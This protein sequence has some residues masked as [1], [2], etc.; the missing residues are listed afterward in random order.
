MLNLLL[1]PHDSFIYH[2]SPPLDSTLVNRTSIYQVGDSCLERVKRVE[3]SGFFSF[4][5]VAAIPLLVN[6]EAPEL[7]ARACFKCQHS[8]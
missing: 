1:T 5:Q 7:T 6:D 4:Y 3:R 2:S 8:S